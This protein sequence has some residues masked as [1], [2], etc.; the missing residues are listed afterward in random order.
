HTVGIP[1]DWTGLFPTDPSPQVVDLPTYAFQRERYWLE[2]P[3]PAWQQWQRHQATI[4]SWRYNVTWIDLA[5]PGTV[6]AL[7]GTWLVVAPADHVEPPATRLVTES[8]RDHGA[9]VELIRPGQDPTS[10][11]DVTGV[12]N[13][14]ALDETPHP[15]HPAVPNGL[16]ATTTLIQQL[17]EA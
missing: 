15:D 12:V 14:L 11:D 3:A 10:Q 1:V 4:D 6:P 17:G 8:L 16:L 2:P 13:L 9:T 7:T 5:R